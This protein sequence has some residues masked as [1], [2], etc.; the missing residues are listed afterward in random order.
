[1]NIT[2]YN[3]TGNL[4]NNSSIR[5]EDINAPLVV[6][7]RNII[8]ELDEIQDILLLLKHD[9]YLESK[10]P[11]LREIKDEYKLALEKYKTFEALK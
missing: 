2:A 7:G 4:I 3:T 1:M 9:V 11:K 5:I 8:K 6:N 10:Y